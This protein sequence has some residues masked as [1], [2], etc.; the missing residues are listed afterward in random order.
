MAKHERRGTRGR[1]RVSEKA[2][3]FVTSSC[4]SFGPHFR[5]C[6]SLLLV[7]IGGTFQVPTGVAGQIRPISFVGAVVTA[8]VMGVFS[9]RLK[10]KSLLLLG[11][12]LIGVGAVGCF[13]A[14]SF[15][16]MMAF[17]SLNGIG[18]SMI[19]PMALLKRSSPQEAH[20]QPNLTPL[21]HLWLSSIQ[22]QN[23]RDQEPTVD[24]PETLL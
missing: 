19:V 10:H 22:L 20:E 2:I 4:S 15:E 7:D 14:P 1:Q 17:F 18:S 3:S 11:A 13:L 23:T 16:Y 24:C 9:V 5:F 12:L 21:T 6:V 8:L